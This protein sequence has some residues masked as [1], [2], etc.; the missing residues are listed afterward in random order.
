MEA[1][2]AL[3]DAIRAASLRVDELR[4]RLV[5]LGRGDLVEQPGGYFR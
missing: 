3:T 1:L 4:E 2:V 5:L